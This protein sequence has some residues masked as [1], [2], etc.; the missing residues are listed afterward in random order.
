MH[1]AV[2]LQATPAGAPLGFLVNAVVVTLVILFLVLPLVFLLLDPTRRKK[3]VDLGT[4]DRPT[5]SSRRRT[6]RKPENAIE[7]VSSEDLADAFPRERPPRHVGHIPPHIQIKA[8]VDYNGALH[9][10]AG[11]E[12]AGDLY[13]QGSLSLDG[14]CHIRGDVIV[15]GNVYLEAGVR[16]SG[17]VR[18]AGDVYMARWCQLSGVIANRTIEMEDGAVVEGPVNARRIIHVKSIFNDNSR[19]APSIPEALPR[20]APEKPERIRLSPEDIADLIN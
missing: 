5:V 2:L 12:I 4:G 11:V 19:A 10:S 7:V 14:G 20:K 6:V 1:G 9:V 8:G 18:A 16:V 17:A 13:T 15:E 3:V